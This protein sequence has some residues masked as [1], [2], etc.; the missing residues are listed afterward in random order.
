[1]AAGAASLAVLLAAAGAA[2]NDSSAELAAGGLVLRKDA[3]IEMRS[4][5]LFISTKAVRV[6]YR[7]FNTSP[8]PVTTVVA[9][10][11]PDIVIEGVDDMIS[12]PT[13]DPQNILGFT[14]LVDGR[15]VKAEVEQKALSLNDGSDQTALLRKLGVP[16]APHLDAA[17]EAVD[18]LPAAAQKQL[19]DLGMATIDEF[20]AGKGWER[21][22]RPRWR[23]KTT[24]YWQQTFPAGRELKVEHRYKPSVGASAG[25]MVG[26]PWSKG[27]PELQAQIDRFCMDKAFLAAADKA[28]RANGGEGSPF[29]EERLEYVL[30]TGGNWKKPIGDFRLTVDKGKAANLVSFC[31]TGVRKVS[32][33]RFE[34]R[35]TNWRPDRDLAILIL[36]RPQ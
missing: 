1:M 32:P 36:S 23:L 20:D 7:F 34:V 25:T 4:E 2:A 21:H 18:R 22:V 3:D 24:Y 29:F 16:L 19:L 6:A 30:T 11:M 17:R 14:T 31:A 8:K 10:P 35:K 13:E 28:T 5:D 26:S 12:I 27:T 15:P 9:F 33:T